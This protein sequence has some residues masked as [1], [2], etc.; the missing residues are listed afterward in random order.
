MS[1]LISILKLCINLQDRAN[2]CIE[3]E[4][5]YIYFFNDATNVMLNKQCTQ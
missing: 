2:I 4:Y 1:F 3:Q 5:I